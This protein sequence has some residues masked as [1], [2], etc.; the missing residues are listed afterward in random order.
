MIEED[1][2][3]ITVHSGSDAEPVRVPVPETEDRAISLRE[4]MSGLVAQ[5]RAVDPDGSLT[6]LEQQI[7]AKPKGLRNCLAAR[8]RQQH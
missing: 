7:S 3:V 2:I 8:H 1:G 5:A 4:W 6:S